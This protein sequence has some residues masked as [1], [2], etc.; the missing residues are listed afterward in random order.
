MNT[1][2][3]IFWNYQQV[4]DECLSAQYSENGYFHIKRFYDEQEI[5]PVSDVIKKHHLTWQ[6]DNR[7]CY[8]NQAVNSAYLTSAKYLNDKQRNIL[9]QFIS[10]NKLMKIVAQTTIIKPAFMNTQLFFNPVNLQQKNYWHRDPQYH[11]SVDEQQAALKGSEVIH[12]R[13]ALADEPGI[14]LIPGTHKRWDNKEELDI[15]LEHEDKHNYDHISSGVTIS[16][17][18]GDLLVFSANMIHRG[19]YGKDR[20]ALDIIFCEAEVNLMTFVDDGCLPDKKAI[21]NLQDGTA[22][23]N[24]ILLKEQPK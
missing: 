12:F 9:F 5:A 16:L 23:V 22:L 20:L 2:K 24:S 1:L 18:K 17:C 4:K 14:E 15:R 11:L 3:E 6:A 7:E 21:I 8:E 19:L 10:T 13:I